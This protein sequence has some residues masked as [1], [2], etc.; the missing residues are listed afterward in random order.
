MQQ[1][2]GFKPNA[3]QRI[4]NSLGYTGDMGGFQDY[5]DQNPDKQDK[6]NNFIQSAQQMAKGGM[7]KKYATG[8]TVEE[9]QDT[10]VMQPLQTSGQPAAIGDETV[11]RAFQPAL[12]Y[13]GMTQPVGIVEQPDQLIS[14]DSGQVTGT[15]AATATKAEATPAAGVTATPA[16]T[17]AP[18]MVTDQAKEAL[19]DVKAVEGEVSQQAQTEAAQQTT[20]SVSDLQAAQGTAVMMTNPV[21]REIQQGELISG[22]ADAAKAATF[23]EQVQAAEATPSKQATVQGQLEGLMEQFEGGQTPA[24]AAG[25]MRNAMAVMA[26]RGLGASSLAGQAAV[27]AAME[28]ALPIAQADAN[29]LASFEMKNLSNR[30]ERAMLAA[31]QRAAFIGQEFDQAFQARVANAAK[32]S[33]VANMNFTAE[34]QVALENARAANTVN[35]ANLSNKQAMVMAEAAA[36]SQLDMANLNNRQ[37][38]AVQNAQNFLQMDMANLSNQ[39]QA[40]M[41]KAQAV[42]SALFTDQAARNAAAQFN[43]SSENQTN[44]F[45]ANLAQQNSQFNSSQRNAM[46]QFN[47]GEENVIGRFNAELANQRDQFN[48]QNRL[49]IDQ[50][51]AVWRR[52]IATA[53]SAAINRANEIN[54]AAVL[55][56]SNNAYNNLWTYYADSMEY[57]WNS[58]ENE[59][60]RL[61]ALALAQFQADKSFELQDRQNDYNSSAAFGSLIATALLGDS[62]GGILGDFFGSK[63]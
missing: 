55:N 34:Q 29:T 13:G 26:A 56:I 49:V 2:N 59:R 42:Q 12:P 15:V 51:N 19:A 3:M 50:S 37:Q 33:D 22:A 5:L 17:V 38:A 31:Q 7:A 27:Q 8:G 1:F 58:A 20:T 35:L 28:S 61:H 9:T 63:K 52:E 6:M 44:Q 4:A 62:A 10:G 16:A 18:T 21:Q 41:F 39:Q 54:A 53:D 32:I 11:A 25:A 43:A 36:L 40:E 60:E 14:T 46:A 30:Q 23:T 48:A 24:W 45:F 47:A 57:A